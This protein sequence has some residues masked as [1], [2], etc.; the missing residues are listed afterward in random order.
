MDSVTEATAEG[1]RGRRPACY[2]EQWCQRR[3]FRHCWFCDNNDATSVF[4]VRPCWLVPGEDAHQAEQP[5]AEGKHRALH[6]QHHS[7]GLA[8][9]QGHGAVQ[10]VLHGHRYQLRA[11]LRRL[12]IGQ[13][14]EHL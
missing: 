6:G 7:L 11:G 4:Q 10:Q 2:G 14:H 8:T 13:R 5:G 3:R 1:L 12:R 9:D